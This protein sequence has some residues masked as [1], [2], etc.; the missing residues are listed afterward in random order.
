MH[1]RR[2]AS[3]AGGALT[4][5]LT[6]VYVGVLVTGHAADEPYTT[7]LLPAVLLAAAAT[8]AM[9]AVRVSEDRLAWVLLSAAMVTWAAA[10]LVYSLWISHSRPEPYPSLADALWLLDYPLSGAALALMLRRRIG[11]VPAAFW[12]DGGLGIVTVLAVA[13]LGWNF[14]PTAPP[15]RSR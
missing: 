8:S 4:V 6:A 1:A 14:A 10:E 3:G 15:A 12:V 11:R 13:F 9:R 2:P 7:W 5:V